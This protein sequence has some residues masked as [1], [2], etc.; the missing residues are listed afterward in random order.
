SPGGGSLAGGRRLSAATRTCRA[1][2]ATGS[3]WQSTSWRPR[4]SA[5]AAIHMISGAFK[6][7]KAGKADATAGCSAI[8]LEE[9]DNGDGQRAGDL[10]LERRGHQQARVRRVAHVGNLDEDRWHLGE[11][12]P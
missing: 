5:P 12:E 3:S 7:R 6:A 9:A 1:G 2:S 4:D 11:V 8:S 10:L